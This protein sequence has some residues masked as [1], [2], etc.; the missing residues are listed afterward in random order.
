MPS[1]I[2]TCTDS[3]G[4]QSATGSC[5]CNSACEG[6]GDCCHDYAPLCDPG[7]PEPPSDPWHELSNA[8]LLNAVRADASSGHQ[9]LG[10]NRARE[11][12]YAAHGGVGIDVHDG[13]IEC[14]YTGYKTYPRHWS[15]APGSIDT[16]HSWPKN[17][18]A[19]GSQRES[20]LH[21]LFPSHQNANSR[22]SSYPYGETTCSG[23]ACDYSSG[24]SELGNDS[25]G[26]T[27]FQVRQQYR[28]DVAR[29]HFY[30]AARYDMHIPAAEEAELKA[31]HAEDPVSARELQRND[32]IEGV[33]GNRNPFVDYPGI[34][35][36][37]SNF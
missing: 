31:W 20:D 25:S 1:C 14:I 26:R 4:G 10:Y 11:H 22:R 7:E 36:R 27:V 13:D 32:A 8:A 28:G 34:V 6:Y 17:D 33:Q 2:E 5:W 3:C 15:R 21:H 19:T 37:I 16:E 18:G 9:T 29:A 24:G 35:D 23:S 30:F 12:M